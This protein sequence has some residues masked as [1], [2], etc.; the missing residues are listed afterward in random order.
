[1]IKEVGGTYVRLKHKATCH[2]GQVEL[3]FTCP[4]AS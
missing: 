2:C 4:M 1:M 3:D